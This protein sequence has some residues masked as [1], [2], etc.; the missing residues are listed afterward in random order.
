VLDPADRRPN[1]KA[2]TTWRYGFGVQVGDIG[3]PGYG[4]NSVSYSLWYNAMLWQ[5]SSLLAADYN[6]LPAAVGIRDE[7]F[8]VE[9]TPSSVKW[10]NA[11]HGDLGNLLFMDGSVQQT[12]NSELRKAIEWNDNWNW[13]LA[14]P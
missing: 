14:F 5:P 4:N 7:P 10:T 13:R 8:D 12:D 3:Y 2:A 1:V 6:I 11:V 9:V